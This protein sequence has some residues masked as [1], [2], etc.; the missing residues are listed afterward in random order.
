M[1]IINHSSKFKEILICAGINFSDH[2]GTFKK[3]IYGDKLETL[4]GG[5][6]RE[7]LC[8]NSS[9]NVIRGMHFQTKPNEVTKFVTCIKGS[10]TDVFIDIRKE[11]KTYGEVGSYELNET[12]LYSILIP[13]GFAHGYLVNSN[14]ATV[15]YAQSGNYSKESDS[16]INPLSIN[17]DWKVSSPIMSEKDT[18][19]K[20]FEDL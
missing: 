14:E 1:E 16:S 12:D 15:V 8:V 9:K 7:I 2:R 18:N 11:S 19:S 13:K 20:N 5:P 17:Y 6:I 10:I 3:T 4:M